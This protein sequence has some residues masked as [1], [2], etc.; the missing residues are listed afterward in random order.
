MNSLMMEK[1]QEKKSALNV[2]AMVKAGKVNT[3]GVKGAQ[4]NPDLDFYKMI[5]KSYEV[6]RL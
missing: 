1:R 3:T 5:V 6:P 2:A 4:G